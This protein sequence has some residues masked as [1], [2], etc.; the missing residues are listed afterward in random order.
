MAAYGLLLVITTSFVIYR[1]NRKQQ[2]NTGTRKVFHLLIVLVYV[3]G[4]LYQC[5]FLYLASGIML[6]VFIVLEVRIGAVNSLRNANFSLFC[7][8][9]VF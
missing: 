9:F 8:L 3:P 5:T 2:T 7:R 6:A 1:V 4:L